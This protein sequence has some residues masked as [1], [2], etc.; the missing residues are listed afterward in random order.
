MAIQLSDHFTGGK[1]IRFVLPS[2]LMMIFV[3]IYGVVDGFFVSNFVGKTPF[4]AVNL[5]MPAVMILG[6]LGMIVG[7]GGSAIVAKTMG[8]GD[9]PKANRYFSLMVYATTIGGVILTLAGFLFMPAIAEG[10]GADEAMM[11]HCVLYGRISMI[12]LPAYMLEN[13]FQSF[14]I[15]AER[16]KL[17]FGITLISGITNMALD[18]LFIP[19]FG[20]GVAGAALA[21]A[22]SEFA[23]SLIP[24]VYF[25]RKNDSPLR[26]GRT[27]VEWKILGRTCLNGSSE[28]VSN[29]AF[30]IVSIVYNFQLLKLAAEDGVAAYGVMM[31]VNF[32]FVAVFF[33]FTMGVSPVISFHFGAKNREEL[34]NLFR[35]GTGL[36]LIAGT[37][38]TVL[39][40]ILSG[41]MSDVFVGYD[42]ELAAMTAS[43]LRLY[44]LGF[45]VTGLNIFG[46]ALFTALNNGLVS[47]FISATRSFVFK[48]STVMILPLFFGLNGVWLSMLVSEG[49]ALLLTAVLVLKYRGRYRYF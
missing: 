13:V 27:K 30:S 43:G 18:A 29:T 38:M 10:L 4:A 9:Y 41:P 21:T 37:A 31:Y 3:S 48:I 23:G 45:I 19:V 20:W 22:A 46:S 40:L 34:Q 28:F 11:P 39:A 8:E 2:I 7:T 16:P 12:S 1:L 44:A 33:G 35:L 5:I 26:L 6:P 17:G 47:A 32:I 42:A 49:L 15:T 24:L 14:M 36:T 25:L